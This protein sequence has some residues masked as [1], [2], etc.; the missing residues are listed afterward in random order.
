[1]KKIQSLLILLVLSTSIILG[2]DKNL[3][4]IPADNDN[5]VYIG[6]F[7][8]SDMKNPK[9]MYSGCAI[10]TV[11]EGT[12]IEVILKDDGLK[13]MFN[14]IL[15]D[16][17]F[18]L[19]TD[20]KD[21]RYVLASGLKKGKHK[22]EIIR[23]T[24]WHGGNTTFSGFYIDKNKK[25]E[26]PEI[27][28]RKIEFIGDSYTCGYGIEGKSNEEHFRYETENNYL[29]FGAVTA[30]ML[31]AEYATVCRS[32]IGMYQGYN[33]GKGFAM[34]VYYDTVVSGSNAVWDYRL[35]QPQ[36]VVITLGGNDMEKD[37]DSTQF[38]NA[39]IK[40]LS[41]LRKNYPVAKIICIAGPSGEDDK[42]ALYQSV[43]KSIVKEV[44]SNEKQVYYFAFSP[45]EMHGSDWHPNADEHR[46]MAEELV[47]AIEK[48]TGW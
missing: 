16:S 20:R 23:R 7:D 17:L 46:K 3:R 8:F 37:F 28:E 14:V 21:G 15:D 41:K 5:I 25:L 40:F 42:W 12:S 2:A 44:G 6:R 45:F 32:G 48:I 22:L 18:V 24:E 9:F 36:V 19:K 43:V 1:M 27:E 33:A 35:F 39:Y 13:N 38:V 10:R 47:P 11:F 30:R 29:T 34:P 31:N 4:L 26:K